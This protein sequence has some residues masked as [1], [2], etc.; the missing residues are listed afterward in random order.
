MWLTS[1][2][3]TRGVV[4]VFLLQ[5]TTRSRV[6][7]VREPGSVT[8]DRIR[9]TAFLRKQN[10]AVVC[11]DGSN[12]ETFDGNQIRMKLG[13]HHREPARHRFACNQLFK[14]FGGVVEDDLWDVTLQTV[15]QRQRNNVPDRSY[16]H[17]PQSI[18][19]L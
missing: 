14:A 19:C 5:D 13:C 15:D 12:P 2:E 9:P 1:P 3:S 11:F 18:S 7:E 8:T 10:N 6:T 4:P 17:S 16:T